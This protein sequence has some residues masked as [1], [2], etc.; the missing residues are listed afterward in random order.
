MVI[1][2]IGKE[3]SFLCVRKVGRMWTL[4]WTTAENTSLW[5]LE[6]TINQTYKPQFKVDGVKNSRHTMRT[7][8]QAFWGT[9]PI[10]CCLLIGAVFL[11]IWHSLRE[12]LDAP[13]V[14]SLIKDT[15]AA[16]E[17]KALKDFFDMLSNVG[18]KYTYDQGPKECK[19]IIL[20]QI[21]FRKSS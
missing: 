14:M 11:K 19:P 13:N 1:P 17:V 9:V 12:V 15:K 3:S 18:M 10:S 21:G 2:S 7:I 5:A 6:Q 8:P 16:Q 4:P 20:N